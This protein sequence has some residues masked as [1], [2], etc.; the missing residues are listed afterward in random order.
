MPRKASAGRQ[1]MLTLLCKARTFEK[2]TPLSNGDLML[3][4]LVQEFTEMLDAAEKRL[5]Q[6]DESQ[7]R[8]RPSGGKW[9]AQEILGHLIDSAS[10]NHQRFVRLQIG[11]DTKFPSYEQSAWVR[12]QAY[13]SEPWLS[14]VRFWAQYNRHLLH[15]I[16]SLPG[17]RLGVL[18][19]V[20]EGEPVTFEFLI[21]DYVRHLRHHLDQIAA[22]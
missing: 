11:T 10:N 18:C 3:T 13:Q 21:R 8:K 15:V 2:S 6:L 9:S 20:G 22:L 7:A 4:Q 12:A 1:K 17:D 16:A 5:L 19:S 14:L